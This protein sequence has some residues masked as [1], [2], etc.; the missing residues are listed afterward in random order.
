MARYACSF[1]RTAS[2]TLAVGSTNA[3]ATRPRRGKWYFA[4]FGSEAA[5]ADNAFLYQIQRCTTAGTSTAVT[6]QTLDPADAATEFD[7]GENHTVNP[8]MTASAFLLQLPLNQRSTFRWEAGIYGEVI[9][10]AVAS[11]GL[12]LMTPTSSAVVITSTVHVE[13][14]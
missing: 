8:T 14:Q 12:A 11:N 9:W 4:T 1:Q 6:P 5:P 3:D 13:E 7:A 10:P 2:L